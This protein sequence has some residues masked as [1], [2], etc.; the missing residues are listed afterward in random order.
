MKDILT[1]LDCR[2]KRNSNGC[3]VWQGATNKGYGWIGVRGLQKLV[4][5]IA[6]EL[7][8]GPIPKGY[9]VHHVCENR[10]CWNPAHLKLLTRKQHIRIHGSGEDYCPNGHEYTEANTYAYPST[11]HRKCRT[12]TAEHLRAYRLTARY[13]AYRQTWHQRRR[14]S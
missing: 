13:R 3:W 5:R 9:D 6:W 7:L 4:H 11:G 10:R 14:S 2:T 12:C 8:R 1:R